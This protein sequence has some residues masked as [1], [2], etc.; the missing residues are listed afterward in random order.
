MGCPLA[1]L[2]TG[3]SGTGFH[4]MVTIVVIQYAAWFQ[5]A[6]H[7]PPCPATDA[8]NQHTHRTSG[9]IFF[10]KNVPMKIK[11]MTSALCAMLVAGCGT[12][13]AAING[14]HSTADLA[15]VRPSH[16]ESERQTVA[17]VATR[18]QVPARDDSTGGSDVTDE[19]EEQGVTGIAGAKSRAAV[20]QTGRMNR[21]LIARKVAEIENLAGGSQP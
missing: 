1:A 7:R 10:A 13:P 8:G 20:G 21:F 12:V 6:I 18:A 17:I 15:E 19:S 16:S 3:V 2:R 9:F 14:K 5:G 11:I 4:P